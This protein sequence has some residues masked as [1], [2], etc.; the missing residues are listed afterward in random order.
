MDCTALP[1]PMSDQPTP[2]SNSDRLDTLEAAERVGAA[3]LSKTATWAVSIAVLI[4]SIA[5]SFGL[6]LYFVGDK[7]LAFQTTALKVQGIEAAHEHCQQELMEL[8]ARVMRL[9]QRS[10]AAN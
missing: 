7:L 10:T 6:V 5:T 2:K 4:L 9:E 8:R 1:F 3:V